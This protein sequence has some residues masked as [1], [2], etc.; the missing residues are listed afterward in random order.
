MFEYARPEP[1]HLYEKVGKSSRIRPDVISVVAATG[2]LTRHDSALVMLSGGADSVCLLDLAVGLCARVEAIHLN[3]GLRDESDADERACRKLAAALE[4]PLHVVRAELTTSGNLHA[5]ARDVRYEAAERVRSERGLDLIAVAHTRDD[6]IET[7]LYRLAASPGRRAL[8]GMPSRRGQIVR[9]LLGCGAAEVRA[10]LRARG[11]D[12]RED[13]SNND[14]RFA[15]A[16]IRSQMAP[17]L[18]E[19]HPAAEDNLLETARQLADEG[20]LVDSLVRQ[21]I[22]DAAQAGELDLA[23]LRS[24]PKALARL[25]LRDLAEHWAGQPVAVTTEMLDRVLASAAGSQQ[26]DLPGIALMREYDL[27]RPKR[28]SSHALE[29]V[30]LAGKIDWGRW[31]L[32][33]G[34]PP[35]LP[36][37]ARALYVE[38]LGPGD[39]LRLRA[40]RAG[41]RIEPVGMSGSK[42][43]QDLFVDRK[44]PQALRER[45][46]VVCRGDHVAWVPGLAVSS[47]FV[48]THEDQPLPVW[49]LA[50]H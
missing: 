28:R 17:A 7:L 12:W 48:A 42:S 30:E 41:D 43:L 5:Q 18:R 21:L 4:V 39:Q 13:K 10:H 3:Y 8:R 20:E 25:A 44:V 6:Q 37:S 46:P 49:A 15:R 1:G 47:R 11:I 34:E 33:T 2:L 36:Q 9:P 22:G 45:Y 29:D 23:T 19:I 32:G 26:I 50:G 14:A 35:R 27:L 38:L 24:A 31:T 16:R 40:R